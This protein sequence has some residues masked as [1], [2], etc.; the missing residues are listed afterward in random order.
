M[1]MKKVLR[2]ALLSTAIVGAGSG[3]M[4]AGTSPG[5]DISN[6]IDVSYTSNGTTISRPNESSVTFKVDRKV[7][8]V[9]EGQDA[10]SKVTVAQDADVQQLTFRLANEGNDTS[11]FDINVAS[12]GNIGLT[13]GAGSGAE[14]TYSVYISPNSGPY[15][16]GTDTL[17]DPAGTVSL[18]D[19]A[20]DGVIFVK[21]VANIPVTAADSDADTFTLTATALDA[22]TSSPTQESTAPDIAV[23]DTFFA[24]TD[25]DGIEIDA[26]DY[27]VSA[28][29]MSASKVSAVIS[30]NLSGTFDCA[31]GA[32]DGTEARVPGGCI[33]Y[34]IQVSNGNATA[35]AVNLSVSDVLPSD[36]TFVKVIS[37]SGFDDV[38]E[39][40]GTI[41]ATAATLPANTNATAVYRVT[42]D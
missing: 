38:T 32:A 36:V 11:G 3:A 42:I 24:D 8:F 7:D 28:P 6:S 16:A 19:I 15:N 17:Y 22:G 5:V 14:G 29:I 37:F 18:G 23:V 41:T 26:E 20:A 35:P 13:N 33:E 9:L 2:A 10:G 27:L 31:N 12:S 30:D 34:T 1:I 4:A 21:V 40:G 39:A 25:A